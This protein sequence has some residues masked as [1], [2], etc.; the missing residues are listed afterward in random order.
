MASGSIS[1]STAIL[2]LINLPKKCKS[3]LAWHRLIFDVFVSRYQLL[4][5]SNLLSFE[6]VFYPIALI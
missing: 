6:I 2:K 5:F 1:Y 3:V 4:F